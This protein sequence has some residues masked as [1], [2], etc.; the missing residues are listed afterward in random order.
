MNDGY[1]LV[2]WFTYNKE[3][4]LCEPA[5]PKTADPAYAALRGDLRDRSY[6]ACTLR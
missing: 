1:D 2:R 6:L 5:R 4:T 3:S